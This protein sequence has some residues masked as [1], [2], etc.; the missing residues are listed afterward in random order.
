MET[1]PGLADGLKQLADLLTR[2]GIHFCVAGGWA[3]GMWATPRATE[4]IDLLA[5][6]DPGAR[7]LV[8]A[9][10]ARDMRL[11][12]SHDDTFSTGNL[13]LW[14]NIVFLEGGEEPVVLDFL[15]ADSPV[16]QKMVER[17]VRV[18]FRGTLL[19]VISLEDLILL[20]ALSSRLQD[21]LDLEALVDS[22][23]PL[24]RDYLENAARQAGLD[25]SGFL[26]PRLP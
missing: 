15:L 8:S 12:Q 24:D 1:H 25:P 18:N 9:A 5:V 4:D 2:L 17:C 14:R 3:V 10:L 16:L 23:H 20:K 11:V 21:R 6:L 19:P 13:S 22:G 7:E 26:P